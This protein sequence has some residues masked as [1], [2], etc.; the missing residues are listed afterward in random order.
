MSFRTHGKHLFIAFVT[1]TVAALLEVGCGTQMNSTTNPSGS[2]VTGPMFVVGHDAPMASVV[3]FNVQVQSVCAVV[4]YPPTTLAQ[5][6]PLLSG[7][8]TVDFARF[9]GLKTLLDMN[10]VPVG[11]YSQIQIT[12][13]PATIGYLNVP[14]S[15]APTIATEAATYPS[16]A[17]TYTYTATL[18][19]PLVITKAG[20]PVGLY[21]DFD[22]RKSIEV[23][24]SG[25]ITGAV[26]PTFNI[27]SVA[28]TDPNGYIDTFIAAVV[29]VGTQSFVVQGPHGQQFT[30]NVNGST[31]WENSE[32]ISNLTTSSIVE[33]SGTLDKADQ[34]LDVDDVAILSQNGFF[35][36]G[37]ITYAMVCMCTLA[38]P[39]VTVDL[40]VR[41]LLPTTTGITLGQIAQLDLSGNEN[42]FIAQM[43]DKLLSQFL[44]NSI[45]LLPGQDIAVGGP[46]SGAANPNQVTVKRVVLRHWGYNGT[47]SS[48]NT[49]NSTFQM[50]IDGFAGVL[51][52]QTITV[53]DLTNTVFRD[54]LTQLSD[55]K[56]GA[57][58]RVV[59]LL[60]KDPTSGQPVLLAHYI[61]ALD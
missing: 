22:L 28:T 57:N 49:A 61:D 2:S 44:F 37:Q 8:P 34:T 36:T 24:G 51:V 31:E 54:G 7:T 35:A 38:P 32:S 9:N 30:I 14:G 52:P 45:Q 33:V 50:Q 41:G 19:S 60:L 27:S 26:T 10:D 56:A 3:S 16:S 4:T 40:Y 46:A 47:V 6:I 23:D 11:S 5:C 1:L 43:H 20:T 13:G 58:V 25:N 39:P 17:S 21:V 53:Y 55:V 42:Y 29:S 15:G 12:L 59:G 18:A 48:V